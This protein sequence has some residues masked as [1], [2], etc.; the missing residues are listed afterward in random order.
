MAA[1]R[2]GGRTAKDAD[3]DALFGFL[4]DH[5]FGLVLLAIVAAGLICYSVWRLFQAF[6]DTEKKGSDLKGIA[7]RARYFLS[8]LIYGSFAFQAVKTVISSGS[9]SGDKMKDVAAELLSK[10]FG[11]ILAGAAALIL[12][13]IGAY[14]I[15]YGLSEKYKKHVDRA[16]SGD[17]RRLLSAAG[18]IGYSARGIVWLLL[19]WLL[20]RAAISSNSQEA[21]DTS[22]AL[23]FLTDQTYGAYFL[24][25]I[26]IGLAC[27]GIFNFIRA[28]YENFDY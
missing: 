8:G 27:Y 16:G 14:Q 11:Q 9:G 2:I 7:I 13:G 20:M 1:F 28:R 24:A 18:K 10:P 15:Y 5:S 26:G 22:K 19:G 6:G 23:D 3:K 4:K 21:G 12:F 17:N 25:M